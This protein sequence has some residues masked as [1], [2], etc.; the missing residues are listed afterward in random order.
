MA[1]DEVRRGVSNN[2]GGGLVKILAAAKHSF[3]I[4]VRTTA[5]VLV[6]YPSATIV[7]LLV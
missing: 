6:G 2:R 3:F 5:L 4:D 7:H 1:P